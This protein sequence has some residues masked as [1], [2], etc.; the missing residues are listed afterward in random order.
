M[1]KQK[2]PRDFH[3][4]KPHSE[5]YIDPYEIGRRLNIHYRT[6]LTLVKSG[7]LR[8]INVGTSKRA[9][10]RVAIADFEEFQKDFIVGTGTANV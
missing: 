5:K 9:V 3:A 10:Y 2:K 1:S 7:R 4:P 6:A 8:A